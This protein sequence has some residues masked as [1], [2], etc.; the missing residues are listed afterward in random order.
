L[1]N[2]V[3]KY[4]EN[5]FLRFIQQKITPPQ[6][7]Q[8][9]GQEISSGRDY[10]GS[11][12]I[13]PYNPDTLI[14]TKGMLTIDKMKIDE[15]VKSCFAV[16]KYLILSNGWDVVPANETPEA[17]EHADYIKYC[18][19]KMQGSI[20]KSIYEM[21]S[22]FE[23]G[24]SVTEKV[25]K[26]FDNGKYKNKVGIKSLKSRKPH[27]FDFETDEYGNLLE[28]G[29]I[30]FQTSHLEAKRF[31]IYS[32]N[33]EFGNFYGTSDC[34]AC[35][36]AWWS[37]DL[38]IKFWNIY[39]EKFGMP[40]AI[41]TYKDKLDEA[42]KDLYQ[43]ILDNI[44][45]GSSII[46]PESLLLD[47]KEAIKGGETSYE[48]AIDKYNTMIAR[49]IL[50]PDLLG[51]SGGG[52]SRGS[53]ALGQK[54]FEMYVAIIKY[55]QKEIGE[56]IIGE[57]LIRE[58]ITL[59]YGEVEEL[60]TFSLASPEGNDSKLKSEIAKMWVDTGIV[61]PKESWIREYLDIPAAEIIPI[62]DTAQMV[63]KKYAQKYFRKLTKYE[64]KVDFKALETIIEEDG[65]SECLDKIKPVM[66][67]II[68]DIQSQVSKIE[69]P[70]DIE[71]ISIKYIGD[72]KRIFADTLERTFK[73][74]MR[75]AKDEIKQAKNFKVIDW[76]ILP[77]TKALELFKGKA[78]KMA[79]DLTDY[80]KKDVKETLYA[81]FKAGRSIIQIQSD[82]QA[83]FKV[84]QDT[85]ALIDGEAI[86][87]SRLE[88]IIRTNSADAV[89][90]GRLDTFQDPALNG[91]VEAF[92]YSAILDD[93]TT[94]LCASLDGEIISADDS[95]LNEINP[96]NHFNCRSI[97]VPI[98]QVDGG[99][100][101]SDTAMIDK[102]IA[103]IPNGFN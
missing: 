66:Q 16:K 92:Q 27:Y 39:L 13:T 40:L 57:Q 42:T 74:G 9:I 67:D 49:A 93:R 38:I 75:S 30:Q 48:S 102:K 97:L 15:Q 36:R 55:L 100:E 32:Y 44:Q 63:E 4:S 2:Q 79:G 11:W 88:T 1:P 33:S 52:T 47:F 45:A 59:N 72:L 60:P 82:L 50:M 26:V 99:Y 8:D 31:I 17:Q 10:L 96:P 56:T 14:N 91:F 22:S 98:T 6:I 84:W 3:V 78:F 62:A 43:A 12:K 70:S 80:M 101:L 5:K 24:F 64:E 18:F 46:K 58:L 89:N 83:I 73:K 103:N 65:V 61:N 21:C 53:Y 71:K 77:A 35:Y 25:Y 41:G 51:F 76:R 86:T 81:G 29:V 85:G 87:P 95:R 54:Q 34:R 90:M 94:E 7:P 20:E 23:Y 28:N 37:K 68:A 19:E 69:T